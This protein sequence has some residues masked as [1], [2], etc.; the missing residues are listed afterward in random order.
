MDPAVPRQEPS[1]S[2]YS[3]AVNFVRGFAVA[4]FYSV[5]AQSVHD[6]KRIAKEMEQRGIDIQLQ[7]MRNAVK[8]DPHFGDIP[9]IISRAGRAAPWCVPA[10]LILSQSYTSARPNARKYQKSEFIFIA[11][12]G[13]LL[14]IPLVRL[15]NAYGPRSSTFVGAYSIA[16]FLGE[17][18]YQP[19]HYLIRRDTR[20]W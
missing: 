2:E 9:R 6:E 1:S 19:Y 17:Q 16:A 8:R 12:L 20:V 3:T 4:G 11:S 7:S 10:A 5:A 18:L 15:P 13:A 14:A